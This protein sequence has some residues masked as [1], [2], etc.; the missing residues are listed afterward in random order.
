MKIFPWQKKEDILDSAQQSQIVKAVQQ[1][2]LQTSGEV[3]VFI[4]N[5]CSY[6]DALDR[7]REIFFSLKMDNTALRNAVLVYVA[8]KDKQV[9]IF[10]DEGIHQ[11]TGAVYWQQCCGCHAS[12]ISNNTI[13]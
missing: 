5:K 11:K 12:A 2:E 4:E 8:V 1:A 13:S 6:M 10:A 9:A 3:R 7:A